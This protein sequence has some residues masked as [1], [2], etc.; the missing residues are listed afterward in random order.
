MAVCCFTYDIDKK[1]NCTYSIERN[2]VSVTIEY[3]IFD[4]IPFVNGMKAIGLN[5]QF[6]TRDILI[7]D[8]DNK[9]ALLLKCAY[10]SGNTTRYG[11]FDNISRSIFIS[12]YCFIN[13]NY[14]TLLE[15]QDVPKISTLILESKAFNPYID[16]PSISQTYDEEKWEIICNRKQNDKRSIKIGHYNINTV[17]LHDNWKGDLNYLKG[18]VGIGIAGRLTISFRRRVNYDDLAQKIYPAMTYLQLYRPNWFDIDKIIVTINKHNYELIQPFKWTHFDHRPKPQT[19]VNVD[20]TTFITDCYNKLLFDQR[21]VRNIPYII[22]TKYRNIED[23]FLMYYRFIECYYK[24]NPLLKAQ[25]SF[26]SRG[27]LDHYLSKKGNTL[28]NSIEN[29]TQE[30]IT[31]RN[32]YVHSGYFLQKNLTIRF[33]RDNKDKNYTINNV[34]VEWIYERAKILYTIC[35]D[36][37]FRDLLGYEKYDFI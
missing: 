13:S 28:P 37:I 18:K 5:T 30:I 14:M 27:I 20:L 17:C 15:L 10:Y 34:D 16:N 11:S 1:Y 31:L 8:S 35:I 32:K 23:N 12:D 36:I 7:V 33:G 26:I 22:L 29:I 9:K 3:D 4:E 25:N 24:K 6:K 21:D 19:S 2:Q